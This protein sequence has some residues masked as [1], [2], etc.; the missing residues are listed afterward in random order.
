MAMKLQPHGLTK[1]GGGLS[2]RENTLVA[3]KGT[4]FPVAI[5]VIKVKRTFLI[6]I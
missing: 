5:G 6:L 3:V 1:Y 2:I 4:Y